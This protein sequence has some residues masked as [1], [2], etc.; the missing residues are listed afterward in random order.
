MASVY[1]QTDPPSEIEYAMNSGTVRMFS[2]RGEKLFDVLDGTAVDG[3]KDRL[4]AFVMDQGLDVDKDGH[5]LH[6]FVYKLE[7]DGLL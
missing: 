4:A 6:S 3:W 5:G 2:L 1:V 7:E